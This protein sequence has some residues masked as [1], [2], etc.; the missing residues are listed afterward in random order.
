MEMT[1]EQKQKLV[2]DATK[3][4]ERVVARHGMLLSQLSKEYRT[5]L[6]EAFIAGSAF[7]NKESKKDEFKERQ[8]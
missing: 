4:I 1:E 3:E 2:H 8:N 7:I 5:M 6:I